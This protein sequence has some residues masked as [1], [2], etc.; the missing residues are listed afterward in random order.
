M[1]L[2]NQLYPV[3]VCARD[4]KRERVSTTSLWSSWIFFAVYPFSLS[5]SLAN[6]IL[7]TLSLSRSLSFMIPLSLPR[8][9]LRLSVNLL[10]D[11][12]SWLL[13]HPSFSDNATT[14]R[15][16]LL[17]LSSVSL[18]ERTKREVFDWKALAFEVINRF[19]KV[20]NKIK[21]RSHHHRL[22]R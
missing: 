3:R 15:S 10:S 2:Y 12:I 13:L 17:H 14:S 9:Q 6:N 19:G 7:F 18:L 5:L 1:V 11:G 20:W 8:S 16:T 4:E 22:Q 21:T